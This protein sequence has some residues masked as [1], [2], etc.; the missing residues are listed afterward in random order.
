MS[1]FIGMKK[2]AYLMKSKNSRPDMIGNKYGVTHGLSY[3]PLYF[4]WLQMK[5]R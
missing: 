4:V 1:G 2:R 5:Q 3:H